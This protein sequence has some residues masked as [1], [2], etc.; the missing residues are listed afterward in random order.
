MKYLGSLTLLIVALLLSGCCQDD[1]MPNEDL[2]FKLVDDQGNDL[3]LATGTIEI[4]N[5][6]GEKVGMQL[7]ST[8]KYRT[9]YLDPSH[10]A[11]TVH[12][13]GR[14]TTLS[15]VFMRHEGGKCC[16]GYTS[17]EQV[18][19]THGKVPTATI[20]GGTTYVIQI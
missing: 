15:V 11:Y 12:Y 13:E 18:S 7:S 4:T 5:A 19:S 20:D 1:C 9:A 3:D 6:N 10:E 16:G 14:Q 8:K 17:I 2:V